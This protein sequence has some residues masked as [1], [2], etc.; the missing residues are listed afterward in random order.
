M[1]EVG[2]RLVEEDEL[3]DGD[4]RLHRLERRTL[5]LDVGSENLRGRDG[6][7]FSVN[8]SRRRPRPMEETLIGRP[9]RVC[10]AFASSSSVPSPISATSSVRASTSSGRR[11]G[12]L[13]PPGGSLLI[14][15]VFRER[16][17]S[18][19]SVA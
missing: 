10:Q 1:P 14:S 6:L 11:R 16:V 15:P 8:P 17:R 4:D 13:P 5:S 19:E 18:R 12:G 3:V 2:P 7:F 9:V